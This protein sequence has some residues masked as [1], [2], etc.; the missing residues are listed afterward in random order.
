MKK[1]LIS[2]LVNFLFGR[3]DKGLKPM[4]YDSRHKFA[5]KETFIFFLKFSVG[6][7]LMLGFGFLNYLYPNLISILM[8]IFLFS[9]IVCA[10]KLLHSFVYNE[11]M[12]ALRRRKRTPTA[13]FWKCNDG[14]MPPDR[15]VHVVYESG[16][17]VWGVEPNNINWSLD[18]DN[19]V[20]E[21]KS[22]NESKRAKFR[23]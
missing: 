2:A 16:K 13:L 3:G 1:L 21:Y 9:L 19:P 18:S 11:K 4:R 15:K 8:I 20:K 10:V 17:V 22:C 23:I 5:Q 6:L 7:L 14:S 12:E